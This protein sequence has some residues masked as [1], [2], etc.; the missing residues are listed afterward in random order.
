MKGFDPASGTAYDAFNKFPDGSPKPH[1]VGRNATA[2]ISDDVLL[3]ADDFARDSTQFKKN[4]AAA[5]TNGDMFVDPVELPL[6]DVFGSD[7]QSHVRGVTRLGSKKNPT[8]HIPTDFTDG[9]IKAI[10]KLDENGNVS[11]HTLYPNPKL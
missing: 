5:R 1:K 8:G 6:Q 9:T 3:K 11:L 7:Y 4:V 10:Y 2:F